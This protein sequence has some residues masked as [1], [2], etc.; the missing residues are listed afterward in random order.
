MQSVARCSRP[1]ILCCA[2]ALCLADGLGQF[3]SSSDV[4]VT[5]R[6]GKVEFDAA[7]GEY[8]VTRNGD[9]I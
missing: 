1:L 8:R 7:A 2:A 6:K 4:G 9:N 5:P 3:E